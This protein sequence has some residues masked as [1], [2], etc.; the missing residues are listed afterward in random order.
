MDGIDEFMSGRRQFLRYF[1]KKYSN[2]HKI[3]NLNVCEE[4]N[5]VY[6]EN[7]SQSIYENFGIFFF[8]RIAQLIYTPLYENFLYQLKILPRL[9]I[10]ELPSY[11]FQNE[12]T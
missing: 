5:L 8:L 12:S 11:H 6:T 1:H 10:F 9:F 7:V 2:L 3:M 4:Q